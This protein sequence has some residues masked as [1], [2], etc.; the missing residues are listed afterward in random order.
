MAEQRNKIA[1]LKEQ[2]KEQAELIKEQGR[3]LAE[4]RANMSQN[5]N[6]SN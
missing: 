5:N 6:M 4:V 2:A 3:L 1:K